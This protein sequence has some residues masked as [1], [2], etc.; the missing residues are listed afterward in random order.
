MCTASA[1]SLSDFYNLAGW[2]YVSLGI[3]GLL[4]WMLWSKKWYITMRAGGVTL[5]TEQAFFIIVTL[6]TAGNGW[7]AWRLWNCGNWSVDP[8]PLALYV[9][10]IVMHGLYMLV[11]VRLHHM[12]ET[13]VMWV[14]LLLDMAVTGVFSYFAWHNDKWAGVMSIGDDLLV[15]YFLFVSWQIT[16]KFDALTANYEK[17]SK[18]VEEQKGSSIAA[19]LGL[20]V[21]IPPVTPTVGM[22]ASVGSGINFEPVPVA[23][24]GAFPHMTHRVHGKAH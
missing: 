8:T 14:L 6:V 11:M 23:I 2:V 24:G 9:A 3:T 16:S 19:S 7:A 1:A 18:D 20:T 12:Q 22:T 15:F 17:I 21:G 5:P 4:I 10:M 13:I